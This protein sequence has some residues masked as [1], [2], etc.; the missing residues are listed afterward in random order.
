LLSS[1]LGVRL[2][3]GDGIAARAGLSADIGFVIS[4]EGI[5]RFA[6]KL[7]DR[8]V[9]WENLHLQLVD[10]VEGCLS[11]MCF[12]GFFRLSSLSLCHTTLDLSTNNIGVHN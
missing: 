5:V 11:V 7:E 9:L 3:Q 6:T 10:F 8:L 1:W 2:G 12:F 4:Q